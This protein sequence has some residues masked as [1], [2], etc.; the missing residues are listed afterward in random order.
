[1]VIHIREVY[2]CYGYKFR[3]IAVFQCSV[4]MHC[5]QKSVLDS[6]TFNFF[7]YVQ[8]KTGIEFALVCEHKDIVFLFCDIFCGACSQWGELAS[9]MRK[10]RNVSKYKW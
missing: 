1:M 3:A 6:G 5:F 4:I 2:T 7:S 9:K 10:G 8:I